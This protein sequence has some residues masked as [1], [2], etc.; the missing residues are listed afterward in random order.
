MWFSAPLGRHMSN[1]PALKRTFA[2]RMENIR[3]RSNRT[4]CKPPEAARGPC[5]CSTQWPW[6]LA[7]PRN[8]HRHCKEDPIMGW[9]NNEIC[10]QCFII[11]VVS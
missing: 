8:C 2:R 3:H 9:V 4:T 5:H 7:S 10:T 6:S 11:M 1:C